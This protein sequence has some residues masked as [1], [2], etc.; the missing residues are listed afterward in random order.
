MIAKTGLSIRNCI[1]IA[2]FHAG[3]GLVLSICLEHERPNGL[4]DGSSTNVQI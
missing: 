4:C 1:A 2:R 3:G